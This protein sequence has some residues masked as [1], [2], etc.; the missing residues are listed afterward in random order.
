VQGRHVWD[1]QAHFNGVLEAQASELGAA[2]IDPG[3][4]NFAETDFADEGHFSAAGAEK[5][6]AIVHPKVA[7]LCR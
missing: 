7:E 2:Y 6:A 3:I 1:L 4:D 5:F